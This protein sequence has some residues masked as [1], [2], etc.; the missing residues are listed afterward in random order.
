MITNIDDNVG[1]LLAKLKEWD[2]ERKTLVVFMTDNG[3]PIANLYN[4]G[5]RAAK[6][7]P[8]QG[9]TRVPSFWRWPGVL[10]PGVDVDRLAAH[11]DL[12]P[13]FAELAGAKVPPTVKLDGRSLTPLLKDANADWPDRFLFTHVGR[14]PKGKAA[15]SKYAKCAVRNGRFRLVNNAELYDVKADPGEKNNVIAD[16]PQVV[17]AMRT[18]YDAWWKEVLPALENENAVGPTSNPFKD[19]YLKQFSARD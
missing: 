14:W 1:A 2:L 15:D 4:A 16:H 18:A 11:I 5:M 17:A 19:L 7:S 8:Y 10:K 9:G 3:H 12:F 6:G 13:T